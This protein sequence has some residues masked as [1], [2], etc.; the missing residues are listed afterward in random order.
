MSF[1]HSQR[2]NRLQDRDPVDLKSLRENWDSFGKQDPM[3]AILTVPE[4]KGGKWDPE[5]FFENGRREVA[6]QVS[7]MSSLGMAT[8]GRRALDFGCGVGRTTQAWCEHF[9]EC[10]GVDIAPSMVK[11]AERFNRYGDRC[12]YHL[13]DTDQLDLFTHGSFDFVYCVIVLQHMEPCFARAYL[14]EFLRVL[15]PGGKLVFQMPARRLK[16]AGKERPW[17]RK[18]LFRKKDKNRQASGNGS[19]APEPRMEMHA[20]PREEILALLEG[21]GV[22]VKA[23]RPDGWPGPN[24]E[25][26]TY[27]CIR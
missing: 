24:W 10:H 7:I 23:V 21:W 15:R 22:E 2:G 13:I 18:R 9:D 5:E 4:F 14:G 1:L 11:A 16:E 12:Q 26:W 6:E 19:E 27:Y 3:W 20:I 25:S 17:W 8:R